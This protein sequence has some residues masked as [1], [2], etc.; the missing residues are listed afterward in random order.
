VFLLKGLQISFKVLRIK[1][2]LY[3]NPRKNA[4]SE[5]GNRLSFPG[6][7]PPGEEIIKKKN[8]DEIYFNLPD[9][10]NSIS[11]IMSCSGNPFIELSVA[12]LV[13]LG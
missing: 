8:L 13:F 10:N 11:I 5:Y 2:S 9:F 6:G 12:S 1:A 4:I 7:A 3:P